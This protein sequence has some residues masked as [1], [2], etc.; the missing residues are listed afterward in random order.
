MKRFRNFFKSG[1][2]GKK[3]SLKES[4]SPCSQAQTSGRISARVRDSRL[5]WL[6]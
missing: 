6:Q 5:P 4:S 3:S 1:F 2:D